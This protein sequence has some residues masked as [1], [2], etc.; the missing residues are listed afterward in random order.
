[1]SK[2]ARASVRGYVVSLSGCK[3]RCRRRSGD[4]QFSS[5]VPLSCERDAVSQRPTKTR[6]QNEQL[7][8]HSECINLL[9]GTRD[10]PWISLVSLTVYACYV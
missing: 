10:A 3:L 6:L 4:G 1:M 7:R 9:D 2:V 5:K 8:Y